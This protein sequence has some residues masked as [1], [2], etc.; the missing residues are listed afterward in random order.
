MTL[1]QSVGVIFGANVGTTMTAQSVVANHDEILLLICELHMNQAAHLALDDPDHL[2]KHRLQFE[3]LDKLRRIY[4]VAEH[5]AI[6]LL[7]WSVIA[8]KLPA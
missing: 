7:P 4:S 8:G 2:L 3:I 6:S 5:M 1:V